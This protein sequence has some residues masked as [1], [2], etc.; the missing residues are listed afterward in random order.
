MCGMNAKRF[1]LRTILSVE[2]LG[3]SIFRFVEYPF[4]NEKREMRRLA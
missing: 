1:Q 4:L 2:K 3:S